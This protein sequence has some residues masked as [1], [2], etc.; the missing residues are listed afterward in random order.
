MW[1]RS[2]C[3]LTA[4]S[5]LLQLATATRPAKSGCGLTA[6]SNLLQ[7]IQNS[8]DK[9]ASCGL[10]A[11]SNLLQHTDWTTRCYQVLRLDRIF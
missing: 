11:F 4:F 10:T 6:F 8:A 9:A 2:S 3:G 5:N 7:L 1:S